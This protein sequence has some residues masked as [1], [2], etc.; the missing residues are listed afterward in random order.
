MLTSQIDDSAQSVVN[1]RDV[2][3]ST[4]RDVFRAV[5]EARLRAVCIL[6]EFDAGRYLFSGK[7]QCF[8]WL[9]EL[10][11]NPEFKA[12]TILISKRRLQDIARLAGRDSN[13]WANVLMTM[14]LRPFREEEAAVYWQRLSRAGII[15]DAETMQEIRATCGKHP[16]LLDAYAFYAWERVS[17]ES[18]S[19][20][21][22]FWLR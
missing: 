19:A 15:T 2:S 5:R 17:Q 7:S 18:R 10:C 16:Y 22:G 21:N 6:D 8:H 9:R 11:S 13:Y 20:S 3:F 12:A 4:V 1:N 14:T